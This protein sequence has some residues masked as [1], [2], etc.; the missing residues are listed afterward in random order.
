MKSIAFYNNKG[1]V[2]KTTS[3]INLGYELAHESKVL[4]IDTDGQANCSRF[5][6]DKPKAGLDKA[7]TS[8]EVTPENALCKTRYENIDIVTATAALNRAAVR[9][10]KLSDEEQEEI[11]R[12][13]I[14][15]GSE[16]D[17]V[18][19]DMPPALSQMTEKLVSACDVV[20]IPIE[21]GTFSI[22]GIP[23]V[24]S[25]VSRCGAKFGGC[26][27]TKFD[28]KNSA[29]EQLLKQ[30]QEIL[31]NKTLNSKIPFSRVI[32]NSISGGLT[33]SEY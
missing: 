5:F 16:Y 29:D 32:K 12:N 10:E 11:A 7:L 25:I 2:A 20:F 13:I 26:F 1:G 15:F 23:T 21:L 8:I 17:Y 18:L 30:L 24:T 33:A 6:T 22:Q 9:F 19:L 28:R 3:V 27:V 14:S 31:G 4:I